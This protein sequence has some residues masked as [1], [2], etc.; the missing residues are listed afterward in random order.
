MVSPNSETRHASAVQINGRGVLLF[1]P[2]GSGKSSL[3]ARLIEHCG[4]VLIGDDRLTLQVRDQKMIASPH[5]SLL[6][7]LELRGFGLVRRPYIEAGTIHLA[8]DL[9]ARADVPRMAAPDT[10]EYGEAS[11]A[12]LAL[13][14]HDSTTPIIIQTALKTLNAAAAENNGFSDDGIYEI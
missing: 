14:A 12:R 2:S 10:F 6:G 7:L 4:A 11:V 9:V 5:E 13:H 8:I 1:G 3:A